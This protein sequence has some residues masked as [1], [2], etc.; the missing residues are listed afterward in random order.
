MSL[1]YVNIYGN[2]SHC[3]HKNRT[4]LV[5]LLLFGRPDHGEAFVAA[6]V[7]GSRDSCHRL[8]A[9]IYQIRIHLATT[10]RTNRDYQT[11]EEEDERG[12]VLWI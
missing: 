12:A 10:K 5:L 2:Y 1:Y 9:S 8:L 6:E 4:L 7:G 3:R 11:D